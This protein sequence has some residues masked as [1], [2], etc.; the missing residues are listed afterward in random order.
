MIIFV[1]LAYHYVPSRRYVEFIGE[2]SSM[3][4]T[5]FH[6]DTLIVDPRALPQENDLIVFNCKTCEKN[7]EEIM[8][9]RLYE[10]NSEGCYWL[11]GD[12]RENSFDSKDYGWLC[13]DDIEYHGVVKEIVNEQ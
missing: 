6:G 2:G 7:N 13:E 10:I 11:L 9:K 8:T 4:P 12:N 1:F 3:E 5:L